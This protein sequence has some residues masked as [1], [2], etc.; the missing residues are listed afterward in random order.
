M[1][2][3]Q[4]EDFELPGMW[5]SADLSG[6]RADSFDEA[7]LHQAIIKTWGEYGAHND[8]FTAMRCHTERLRALLL[9]VLP[10]R[11]GA[12]PDLA[13]PVGY[14]SWEAWENEAMVVLSGS[15]V[16]GTR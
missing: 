10:S 5:E 6:G 12:T 13:W 9:A 11:M 14:D 1:T 4:S 3:H 7:S 8:V 2:A 15:P 16:E